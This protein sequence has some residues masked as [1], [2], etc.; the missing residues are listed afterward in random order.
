[1][2][3]FNVAGLN[4]GFKRKRIVCYLRTVEADIIGLQDTHL[5]LQD[6]RYVLNMFIGQI[7]HAPAMTKQKGVAIIIKPHIPLE[8]KKVLKDRVGRYIIIQGVLEGE[9]VTFINL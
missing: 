1:M 8:V 2:V 5:R 6:E 3:S 9:L 7:F 4:N